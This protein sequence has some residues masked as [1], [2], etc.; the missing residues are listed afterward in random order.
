M[1]ARLLSILLHVCFERD[2]LSNLSNIY[3]VYN[4]KYLNIKTLITIHMECYAC[5]S[6]NT[7]WMY[8]LFTY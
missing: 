7:M 4:T 3:D 1:S 6:L 2:E 5:Y 8:V